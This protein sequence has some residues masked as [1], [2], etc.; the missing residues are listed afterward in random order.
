M[1]RVIDFDNPREKAL[2][3]DG[4]RRLQGKQR[5]DIVRYRP[6]RSDNQNAAYWPMVCEPFADWITANWDDPCTPE[7]AHEI[8]KATF[9]QKQKTNPATG[10]Y[11]S[12]V[13]STAELDTAGFGEYFDRCRN[14]LAEMCGI[15]VEDP[16][17]AWKA[18]AN[19]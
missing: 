3:I 18:R 19:L 12:F 17:P 13:Q 1:D 14:L 10:E 7:Q 15:I 2:F 16:D 6:R 8:L 11:F 9:L 5:V 4:A